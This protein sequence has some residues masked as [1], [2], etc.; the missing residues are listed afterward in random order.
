ME[1]QAGSPLGRGRLLAAAH[2][3]RRS[4]RGQLCD[5][6]EAVLLLHTR[7][8]QLIRWLSGRKVLPESARAG[9]Q[10][11]VVSVTLQSENAAYAQCLAPDVCLGQKLLAAIHDPQLQRERVLGMLSAKGLRLFHYWS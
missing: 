8:S 2:S 3:M 10:A 9:D 6:V 1:S 11:C 5:S 4:C 7:H